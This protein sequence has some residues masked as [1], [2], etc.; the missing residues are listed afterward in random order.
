MI[1][2]GVNNLGGNSVLAVGPGGVRYYYAHLDSI[3]DGITFGTEV[4]ADTVIGFVGN[5]GNASGTPPHLHFGVYENGPQNPYP[6]L[7]DR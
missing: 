4:T 2:A 7:V 5:S 1:R 6:L 3:A